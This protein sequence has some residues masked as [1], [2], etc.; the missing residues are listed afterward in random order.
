MPTDE[1][2]SAAARDTAI[3]IV[4]GLYGYTM[5]FAPNPAE[6]RQMYTLVTDTLTLALDAF[7]REREAAVVREAHPY[8]RHQDTCGYWSNPN[9]MSDYKC[10]CGLV[11]FR[12]RAAEARKMP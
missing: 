7:A 1:T 12:A 2:P 10:T 4:D 11:Q 6:H 3:Q 9:A 5:E 8:L